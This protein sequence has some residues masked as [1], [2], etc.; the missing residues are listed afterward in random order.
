M[1]ASR[2]TGKNENDVKSKEMEISCFDVGNFSFRIYHSSLSKK[3]THRA[4]F[5]LIWPLAFPIGN[6]IP[7]ICIHVKH[8]F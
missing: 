2:E 8:S 4:T 6:T 7:K 1:W 5:C 3:S